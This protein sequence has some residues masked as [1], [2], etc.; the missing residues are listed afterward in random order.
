IKK[1]TILVTILHGNN[2]IGTVQ[3]LKR[4]GEICQNANVPLFIDAP[5]S[6]ILVK[7]LVKLSVF[8]PLRFPSWNQIKSLES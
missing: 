8:M 7:L 6:I 5:V 2:E 3:Q 4:I 1:E